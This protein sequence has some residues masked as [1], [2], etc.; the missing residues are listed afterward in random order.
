MEITIDKLEK[1]GYNKV[2]SL[3]LIA[4]STGGA[5][6]SYLFLND[7]APIFSRTLSVL[8]IDSSNVNNWVRKNNGVICSNWEAV[9]PK[10]YKFYVKD[11]K[12]NLIM[13]AIFRYKTLV[14]NFE[15]PDVGNQIR[16]KYRVIKED[17]LTR[18]EGIYDDGRKVVLR[19]FQ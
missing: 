7:T 16:S 14:I 6:I 19:P 15:Y 11:R 9:Y 18:I 13:T 1:K 2:D 10:G 12:S 4:K 8:N 3:G 5:N 17:G